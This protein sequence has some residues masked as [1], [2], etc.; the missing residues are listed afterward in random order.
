MDEGNKNGVGVDPALLI[1]LTAP[2]QCARQF[3]GGLCARRTPAC[4]RCTFSDSYHTCV[5][6]HCAGARPRT[7]I[8]YLGGRFVPPAI[9]DEYKLS[10]P[11]FAGMRMHACMH[12]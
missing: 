8:H 7:G 1:S 11:P 10:L 9:R 2:K 3:T 6:S 5:Y 4:T 12:T